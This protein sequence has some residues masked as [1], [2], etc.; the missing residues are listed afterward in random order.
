NNLNP[1]QTEFLNFWSKIPGLYND[2][3][4]KLAIHGLARNGFIYRKIAENPTSSFSKI[5]FSKVYFCG[6]N[7]VSESELVIMKY[8]VREGKAEVLWE[9]HPELL[10]DTAHEA[11]FFIRKNL[12]VVGE[13]I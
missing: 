6:L 5:N 7:A 1:L 13:N 12:S 4:E 8:L 3:N 10:K 2:L 9:L 11:G